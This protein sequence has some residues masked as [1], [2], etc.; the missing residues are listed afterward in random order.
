MKGHRKVNERSAKGSGKSVK[1]Q[2][3]RAR[4]REVTGSIAEYL[5]MMYLNG[6]DWRAVRDGGLHRYKSAAGITYIHM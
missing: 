4:R 6:M 5:S 2:C 1:G 3:E